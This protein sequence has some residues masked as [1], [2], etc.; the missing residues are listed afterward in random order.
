MNTTS[1]NASFNLEELDDKC[2]F[3]VERLE[4]LDIRDFISMFRNEYRPP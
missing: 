2:I 1:Q 4:S 3:W